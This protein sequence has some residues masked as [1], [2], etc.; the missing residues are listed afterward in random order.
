MPGGSIQ[1]KRAVAA[2]CA[3]SQGRRYKSN[4]LC[5][6]D[7]PSRAAVFPALAPGLAALMAWPVLDHVPTTAE[8]VGLMV[9]MAGLLIAVTSPTSRR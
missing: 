1:P 2:G 7:W 9:A 4:A 8:A 5:A 6:H 3:A